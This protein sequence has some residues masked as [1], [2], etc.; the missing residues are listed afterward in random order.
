MKY[1]VLSVFSFFLFSSVAVADPDLTVLQSDVE[2]AKQKTSRHETRLRDAES[3]STGLRQRLEAEIGERT[4]ADQDF[5]RQINAI[6]LLAGAA[7]PQ[8]P[9]G[10]TGPAGPQGLQGDIG[11]QGPEG[12][13]GPQGLQ[14]STG[15][16]GLDGADGDNGIDGISCWDINGN[17]IQDAS[18]DSNTDGVFDARDCVGSV[19]LS[20]ILLRL[21]YLED[22]LKNTDFDNDGFSPVNGDCNDAVFEVNPNVTEIDGDGVDNDCDGIIDNVPSAPPV[23]TSS[24]GLVINEV[25]YDNPG[26]DSLEYVEIYNSND[27]V[28]DLTGMRLDFINGSNGSVYRSIDLSGAIDANG[29]VTIGAPGLTNVTIPFSVASNAIQNGP[30]GINLIDASS[31]VV[32]SIAYGGAV[33]GAG[34]GALLTVVDTIDGS[35]CRIP[36]GHDS[37]DNANDFLLCTS[38]PGAVNF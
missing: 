10:E 28:M 29:F 20:S 22:R 16:S 34:E 26:T 31:A 4:A 23:E 9:Q 21:T 14:G 11:P 18:E 6:E 2:D 13:E 36:D 33:A 1:S 5:Q 37:D 27:T 7:G 8:G 15:P 17:G 3:R 12:P 19:D 32:D 38:T 30:D 35:I 25:D 24:G